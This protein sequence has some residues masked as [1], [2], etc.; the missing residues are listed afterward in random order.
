MAFVEHA[1]KRQYPPLAW[2]KDILVKVK[3]DE[4]EVS[5][6][7]PVGAEDWDA[8]PDVLRAYRKAVSRYGGPKRQGK[9]SP[10]IEFANADSDQKLARFVRQF[11]PVTVRSV[12]KEEHEISTDDSFGFRTIQTLLVARQDLAELRSERVAYR[13]ALALVSELQRGQRSDH[14]VIGRCVLEIVERVSEWPQQRQR[15]HQLR[16]GGQGY[17]MEPTCLFQEDNLEHLKRWRY[18]ANRE[19]SGEPLRDVFSG[20]DPA[21]AGHFVVCELVNAFSPRVYAWGSTPVE[22]PDWDLTCSGIRPVLYYI[23]RREYLQASGIAI[24]RNTECR[25]VFEIERSGQEFCGDACSRLQRQR[26]Y[27]QRA[28]KKLRKRRARIGKSARPR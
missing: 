9:N 2:G 10:H 1:W 23:L 25:D 16:A 27:W 11:G 4:L 6:V 20:P 8:S 5:A 7:V 12:R 26:E 21:A 19:R 24:C 18:Y 14:A 3:P 22:A 13:S 17:E 15:E 28:G